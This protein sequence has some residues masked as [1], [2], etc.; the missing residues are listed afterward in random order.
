MMNA[1]HA[2]CV[3]PAPKYHYVTV[4]QNGVTQDG[5]NKMYAVI[6]M[7]KAMDRPISIVCSNST[8]NCYINRLTLE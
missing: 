7:A 2:N 1:D 3:A 6:L 4:G 5:A 8:T